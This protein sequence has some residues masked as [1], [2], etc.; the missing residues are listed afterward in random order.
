VFG[1]LAASG[2]VLMEADNLIQNFPL[3][4]LVGADLRHGHLPLWDPYLASGT[5]LL[6]GFN[7]GAAYPGTWLFAV[8]PAQGAWAVNVIAV[9]EF[10]LFGMFVFLRRQTISVRAATLGAATFTFGGFISAQFVHI[11][12]IEGAGWLPWMLIALDGLAEAASGAGDTRAVGETDRSPPGRPDRRRLARFAALLAA[13]YGLSILAGAPEAFLDGGVLA[14]VYGLWLLRR[15]PRGRRRPYL[16]AALAGTAGAVLVGAAQWLPGWAFSRISQRAVPDFAYFTSGSWSI[17]LT[18]LLFSPFLLGT[19][20]D[21]PSYYF[22]PFNFPEVTGYVGVVSVVAVFAL[23]GRQWWR[24]PTAR[25]WKVWYF[26]LVLGL[27]LAWGGYTPFSRLVYLVPLLNKQ[28][29]LNRNLLIVDFALAVLAAW[30]IDLALLRRPSD[31]TKR[32][33]ASKGGLAAE[34][35]GMATTRDDQRAR[36]QQLLMVVPVGLVIALCAGEWLSTT[37]WWENGLPKLLGE[38]FST[39]H[40]GL[41]VMAGVATLGAALIIAIVA[42]ARFGTRLSVSRVAW[43]TALIMAVD[44]LVFN[45]FVLRPPEPQTVVAQTGATGYQ[46]AALTGT[47][48]RFAVYDPDLYRYSDLLEVGQDDLNVLRRLPTVEDYT[49]LVDKGYVQATGAHGQ[50]ELAAGVFSTTVLNQLNLGVLLSV[51]NYFMTPVDPARSSLRQP[52]PPV[53]PSPSPPP[54]N[55]DVVLGPGGSH[56]WYVGGTADLRT[57]TLALAGN[58]PTGGAIGL[59]ALAIGAMDIDGTIHWLGNGSNAQDSVTES[60]RSVMLRSVVPIA[61]LVVRNPGPSAISL[62]P[63]ALG[64]TN[65]G[66]VTLKG[67]LQNQVQAPQW[68]FNSMIGPFAAFTNSRA[69]GWAWLAEPSAGSANTPATVTSAPARSVGLGTSVRLSTTPWGTERYLVDASGPARLVRSETYLRGWSATVT[70]V[71]AGGRPDGPSTR[72]DVEQAGILQMA[73][74]PAGRSIVTFVYQPK[75]AVAGL[76][77]SGLALLGLVLAFM[78]TRRTRPRDPGGD[79]RRGHDVLPVPPAGV[80]RS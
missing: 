27:L 16:V 18:S 59:A 6:G 3:R 77:I 28:R 55:Q 7:A 12:L 1:G 22:G 8:L 43:L 72:V 45:A 58:A 53:N 57:V 48:S 24:H 64:T 2:H 68:R 17:R 71:D 30:W 66:A 62:V 75:L 4:S 36:R 34:T 37:T 10:A 69:A 13:A 23:M 20:Q 63:P 78:V 41:M 52:S 67:V 49:A 44:L 19:N 61:G 5:P 14:A 80:W 50:D 26:A 11:D 51:P 21:R 33:G 15:L 60:A 56:T 76:G 39:N 74:V 54:G 31:P 38:H 42:L 46:L 35:N 73:M 47:G 25:R 65:F 70:P 32:P 79:R 40:D 9:Y 29:L